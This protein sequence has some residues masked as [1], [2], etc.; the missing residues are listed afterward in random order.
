MSIESER[1]SPPTWDEAAAAGR[2]TCDA[3]VVAVERGAVSAILARC[4]LEPDH[5]P[6]HAAAGFAQTPD[7]RRVRTVVTWSTTP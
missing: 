3:E 7:G 5:G 6:D 2:A 4:T 1:L